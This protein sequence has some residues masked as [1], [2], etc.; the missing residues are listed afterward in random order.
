MANP[1]DKN[2]VLGFVYKMTWTV[3]TSCLCLQTYLVNIMGKAY[4]TTLEMVVTVSL[5][6]TGLPNP[7][8]SR[9]TGG[10]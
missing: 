5:T 4:R 7:F 9:F 10:V 2:N 3:H 1:Q 8:V 6:H